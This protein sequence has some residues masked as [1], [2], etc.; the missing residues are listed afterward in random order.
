MRDPKQKIVRGIPHERMLETCTT[1]DEAIAFYRTHW[2]PVLSYAKMLLADRTGAS[3]ILGA[4]DGQFQVFRTNASDG[5]GYGGEILGRTIH[6]QPE[7]ALTNAVRLLQATRQ[8]GKYGT[9]Y[10]NVFDLNSGDIFLLLPG[11]EA[12]IT[13][14]LTEEL[15]RGAHWYDMSRIAEQRRAKPKRLS[16]LLEWV[17]NIVCSL[18]YSRPSPAHQPNVAPQ[19]SKGP[20]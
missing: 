20:S 19:S 11:S 8:E 17:K 13:L 4:H 14:S 5:F 16:H 15:Q 2:D 12:A 18:R 6:L 3:A 7:P 10:S 9:K 1:V